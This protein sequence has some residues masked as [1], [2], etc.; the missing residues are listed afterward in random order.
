[1]YKIQIKLILKSQ[2]FIIPELF[3]L[4]MDLMF[5]FYFLLSQVWII[6]LVLKQDLYR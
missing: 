3:P 5:F 6:A 2:T 1:M 4:I